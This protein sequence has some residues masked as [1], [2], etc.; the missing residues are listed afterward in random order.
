MLGTLIKAAKHLRFIKKPAVMARVIRGYFRSAVLGRETLR[1]IELAVTYACQAKCHKC[2]AA[3]LERASEKS[4]SIEQIRDIIS[5]ALRLGLI[6]VNITGGEPTLRGDL[7]DVVRACRPDKVVISLVTNAL[8]LT[9]EKVREL[10]SA[11]L[12]TLQISLDSADR[13][14]HD[15]LRGVPGCYDSVLAAAAW[16]REAGL[17]LC[18]STVLSTEAE[19]AQSSMIRLLELAEREKAFLLLCD[20]AAVGGWEGCSEKMMTCEERNRVLGELLRHPR[21]RH[22][23]MYNFRVKPGC[24]AGTEKI[25]ITAFGDVT[26]CDLIHDSAGNVL[27]ESLESIWKRMCEHPVYAMKTCDCVRYLDEFRDRRPF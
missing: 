14:T 20:S 10:K 5:Q 27:E 23:A 12:N 19:S 11:G 15:R 4:L 2:Y 9:Q 24:P 25:Y 3:N 13:E 1:S 17:N 8:A 21:A 26:P 7:P 16:A 22:H 18:F 6:H